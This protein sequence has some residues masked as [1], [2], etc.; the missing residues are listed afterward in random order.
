MP[1]IE[2]NGMVI[3]YVMAFSGVLVMSANAMRKPAT[4]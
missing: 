1:P 3:G 4:A 2:K